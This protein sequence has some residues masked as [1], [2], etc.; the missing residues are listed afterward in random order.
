MRKLLFIIN[1]DWFFIS[2]RLPI[3]VEAVKQG[4]EVHIAT[5]VTDSVA[6]LEEC[7]M[8]VHPINLHRSRTGLV[9]VV[10]FFELLF[11]IR[12]IVPDILHL[13]TIK[14]VLL[15]GIAARL[16]RVQAVVSAVSGLGFVFVKRGRVARLHRYL[17]SLLYRLALGGSNQKVIF[18]IVDDQA[19][20][21]KLTGLSVERSVLIHGSGVDISLYRN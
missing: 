16:A 17:I 21:S 14:P 13:I 6:V 20:L 1:V 8:T 10:E 4:Y 19:Q 3:A 7:G 2:H 9:V 18:Q 12:K 5:A 15:G 11:L